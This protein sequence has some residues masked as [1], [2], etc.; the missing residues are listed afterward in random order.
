M[1]VGTTCL[2]HD[3]RLGGEC[4]AVLGDPSEAMRVP[5]VVL[6]CVAYLALQQDADDESRRALI[7]TGFFVGVVSNAKPD[8]S[9]LYFVTAKHCVAKPQTL[10]DLFIRLN[11]HDGG[12]EDVQVKCP[13]V[14]HEDPSVDLAVIP[15]GPSSAIY[16]FKFLKQKMIATDADITKHHLGIGDDLFI[17]G[18]FSRRAGRKRILPIVRFG[19][20]A[21]MPG[22]R[23]PDSKTGLDYKAYLAEVRSFGGLSGS[24]V[25]AYL[26]PVRT[27]EE[28]K[29]YVA[30]SVSIFLMGI[31]RGH[32]EHEE[33]KPIYSMFEDEL[34]HVNWGIAVITPTTELLDILHGEALSNMRKERDKT[35]LQ[36][37]SPVEDTALPV[38]EQ[39]EEKEHVMTKQDFEAALNKVSRKIQPR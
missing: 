11:R 21:A 5:D 36:T 4:Q 20:I 1:T 26:A 35:L 32:W 28:R 15:F 23:L 3:W 12:Y 30:P 33:P 14:I 39:K 6:K 13:W 29:A 7:G 10:G 27:V 16:D 25:F 31:V 17:S 38:R 19:N 18:L 34:K 24:P 2:Y 37:D 8:V 9:Y 22:E